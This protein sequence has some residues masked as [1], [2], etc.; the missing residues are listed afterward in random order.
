[1]TA[2]HNTKNDDDD[3]VQGADKGGVLGIDYIGPY[4]PDVW[5]NRVK[6]PIRSFS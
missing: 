2:K 6:K 5:L 3:T 4:I 1:M